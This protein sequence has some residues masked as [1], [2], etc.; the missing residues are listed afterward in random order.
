MKSA[1]VIPSA[2][3]AKIEERF[4]KA[5]IGTLENPGSALFISFA[6]PFRGI[7]NLSG[8]AQFSEGLDVI[9]SANLGGPEPARQAAAIFQTLALPLLKAKMA[10][11]AGQSPVDMGDRVAVASKGGVVQLSVKLT[12]EDI[13]ALDF[14]P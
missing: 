6:A 8:G 7:T 13:A 3:R 1:L 9:L 4:A 12:A 2:M 14:T 11:G 5:Q 10:K